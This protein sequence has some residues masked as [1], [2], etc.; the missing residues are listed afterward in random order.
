VVLVRQKTDVAFAPARQLQQQILIGDM[1]FGLVL[2]IFGCIVAGKIVDP[3]LA[4]A[5]ALHRIRLGDKTVQIPV[6]QGN[7]EI[8][9][10][11]QSLSQLLQKVTEQENQL[12][13]SNQLLHLEL[14][15]RAKAE[16][17][18]QQSEEH[19]RL[20]LEAARIGIWDWNILTDKITWSDNYAL[21]F[22]LEPGTFNGTYE[23]F[24]EWVHP[25]DRESI[26]QA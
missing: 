20:A 16:V 8:G 3:I 9:L 23:A 13:A 6:R 11:W 2:A 19:L 14:S 26:T 1:M 17:L 18:L 4:I 15:D 7:D 12:V 21:L 5:S 24:N 25:E 10:L 22:G